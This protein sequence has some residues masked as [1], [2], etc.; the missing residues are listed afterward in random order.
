MYNIKKKDKGKYCEVNS[1]LLANMTAKP[2]HCRKRQ[3]GGLIIAHQHRA[4]IFVQ[5]R[6]YLLSA[7][8][9]AIMSSLRTRWPEQ[10]CAFGQLRK[11]FHRPQT[12][13]DLD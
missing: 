7:D 6:K 8:M 5:S 2:K 4:D 9:S 12:P 1:V 11:K 13:H 3:D 10:F